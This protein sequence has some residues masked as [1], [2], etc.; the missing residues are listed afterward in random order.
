M[1][2][3]LRMV[4]IVLRHPIHIPLVHFPIALSYFAV[5]LAALSLFLFWRKRPEQG[6]LFGTILLYDLA[7]L[8]LSVLPAMATG[9]LENQT[10]YNGLAPNAALKIAC[11]SALLLIAAVLTLWRWRRPAVMQSRGRILMLALCVACAAL[12]TTLGF[13]GGIIVWGA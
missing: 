11:G 1:P 4:Q 8:T 6:N 10:R 13:L 12:T 9:I 5:L 2:D 7:L 3:L